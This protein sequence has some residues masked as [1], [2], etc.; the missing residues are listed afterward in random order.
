MDATEPH[1]A[2]HLGADSVIRIASELGEL[3]S[4]DPWKENVHDGNIRPS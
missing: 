4:N 2:L 1:T 3:R